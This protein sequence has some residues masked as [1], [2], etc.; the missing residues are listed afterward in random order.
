M[1]SW[2]SISAGVPQGGVLSPLLFA[3][4]INSI[5]NQLSS[6][7][8]FYADDLQIY[9]QAPINMLSDTFNIIN[10]DLQR[11]GEWSYNYGLM[12]NPMKTQV[13]VIGSP[14]LISKVNW[15]LLPQIQ[16]GGTTLEISTTVKN[17]G[18]YMDN[19]L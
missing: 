2:C 19:T 10:A 8:H 15:T 4:F 18:I 7:Y 12:I 3:V 16:F 5:S 1:S 11:I 6:F 17:L 13:C 9:T 14:R